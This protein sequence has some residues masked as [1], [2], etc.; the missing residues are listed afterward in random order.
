M[1]GDDDDDDIPA[2]EGPLVEKLSLISSSVR[3]LK[4][5]IGSAKG[6]SS[7][8]V[9][10]LGRIFASWLEGVRSLGLVSLLFC[11][12]SKFVRSV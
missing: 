9:R 11:W 5:S 1:F 12:L 7:V 3:L 8:G 4:R 10:G 2:E 6:C